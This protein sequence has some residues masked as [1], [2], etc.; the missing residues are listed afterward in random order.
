MSVLNGIAASPGIAIGRVFLLDSQDRAIPKKTIKESA[1]PREITRFQDALTTTRAE[2]LGIRD[3]IS[4]EIGQEHADI[5]NAHLMVLED[6]AIIEEVMERIKKEKLTSEYIFSQVL[7]KYSESFMKINDEYLRE[8][9][10][11]INDVGRRVIKN[12]LGE[13]RA[14]LSDLKDKVVIVAYDLSPSDTA[15]MHRKNVIGFA[16]DIGG[17]TS[18]TAIMAKSLEIPAVVGLESATRQIQDGDTVVVD[19]SQGVVVVNPT[20]AELTKYRQEQTRYQEVSKGLKKFRDLACITTDGRR[21]ELAANIELPEETISVLSHGA[22]GIG[23]Y[24][25]EFLYMN[26]PDL[27][28]EEEQYQAYKGVVTEMA[29]KPV[30]IRTFDLGGDKFLSHLE[31]PHEMNPFLG[32]RAIRFCLASPEIFKIQLRAI[33][34]A[35]A[36]G[37]LRLMYPMISGVGELREAN[38]LLQQ[39]K[40][41]LSARKIRFDENTEVGAMIEIPSAALTCDILAPEVDFFSIG[42]ND[43]IQYSIAVDRINEKIAYLYEPAHPAVLRLLKTVVETGHANNIWVGI[44]G[45]MAGDP[46]LTPVLLGLGLDEISTSPVMIPEIKKIIRSMSH[47]EAQQVT[48][49]VMTLRTGEEVVN[50]LK[51]KYQ[52][53]ARDSQSKK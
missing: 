20:P 42:T 1:I 33:L 52:Q 11:D 4:Q 50:F 34:R 38:K 43:L 39:A 49:Y 31:M 12:L 5:F 51:M 24:R 7:K 21:I 37:K 22:D 19:G 2:I 35:S 46:A 23:L 40:N 10:S 30:I 14:P 27:P 44:C 41:E 48:Q 45:E 9:I 28:S 32:W 16:T 3:K 36:H 53:I 18:H 15:V 17:R 13:Q 8:R 29:P 25:T 6:R 47:E 26:R